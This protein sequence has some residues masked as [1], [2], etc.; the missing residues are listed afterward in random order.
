MSRPAIHRAP[1]NQYLHLS[2][3]HPDSECRSNNWWL[4]DERAG[5]NIGMREPTRDGALVEAIEY[6]AERALRAEQTL[7]TI[8][9][10]VSA[11]VSNVCEHEDE[12]NDY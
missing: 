8:T 10:K 6:W 12:D 3:C 2:E 7:S 11:F 5:M 9:S 4:Y 1:L